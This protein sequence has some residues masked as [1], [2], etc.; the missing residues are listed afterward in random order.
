MVLLSGLLNGPSSANGV[1]RKEGGRRTEV[2]STNSP[3]L[4]GG[5][6]CPR[7]PGVRGLLAAFWV[8][9]SGHGMWIFVREWLCG[10]VDVWLV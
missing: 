7:S 8:H 4:L 10:H 3:A 5:C 6:E 9:T 1:T 2:A